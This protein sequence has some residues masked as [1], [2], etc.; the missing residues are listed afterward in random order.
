MDM[1]GNEKKRGFS[2]PRAA[3]AS[4]QEEEN[5]EAPRGHLKGRRPFARA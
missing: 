4:M 3:K 1:K 5:E 2:A